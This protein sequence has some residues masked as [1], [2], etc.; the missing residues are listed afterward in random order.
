MSPQ[1]NASSAF[2][3]DD[4][5]FRVYNNTRIERR[6]SDG[7]V[8]ATAMCK[9][10][11]KR[12]TDYRESDRCQQY[13]DA[14]S[15]T[16]EIPVFDLIVSR[17]G[18]GGGTWV[19]PQVAVDLARWISAPF[20]VWMDGWFLEGLKQRTSQVQDTQ[21][22]RRMEEQK[23]LDWLMS[24]G[25]R[26]GVTYDER[27]MLQIKSH[28]MSLAL[29]AAG[30]GQSI[31][32]DQPLSRLIFEQFKTNLPLSNL[33][34]IGRL[35]SRRFRQAF[36]KEPPKHDQYV[37]GANRSVA[38]YPR[39]WAIKQLEDMYREDPTLFQRG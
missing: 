11:G 16:T 22:A 10:N 26:W 39:E 37:D 19:H 33:S 14:L 36:D 7:Y 20:A 3:G 35:L 9:A 21:A 30:G 29:P 34:R 24:W 25:Q 38:H 6:T 28:A 27:D 23:S 13:L 31:Y 32:N 4:M 8:N 12:W 2:D 18:N 17:Q 15:Q 5:V 1:L